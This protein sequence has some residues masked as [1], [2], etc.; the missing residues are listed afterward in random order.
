MNALTG[1]T[2][3]R[4]LVGNEEDLYTHFNPDAEFSPLV[5]GYI[6]SKT[7]SASGKAALTQRL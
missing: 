7:E 4:L 3:I 2:E 6:K 1:S 5:K